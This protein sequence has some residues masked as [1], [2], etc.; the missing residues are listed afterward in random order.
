VSAQNA[1]IRSTANR[2][3]Q[4]EQ[5]F[6]HGR[7]IPGQ[8]S[9]AL[10]YRAHRQ[11]LELRALHAATPRSAAVSALPRVVPGTV[12]TPLGPAPLA[13]DA[14]GLGVQDYGPV[15]GRATAVAIDPADASGNTVY[16]GGA[17]G[18]VW[19][20]TNAGTISP[21]PSSVTWTALTD[22]Q[23]TLAVGAIAIQP[24]PANPDATRSVILVGTGET[25]NSSD[26]YYGLGILRSDNA[27]DTW[28]LIS[29]DSTGNRSFAGL[30]FSKIAFST[31][32]PSLVVAA[33]AGATQG[34]VEGLEDPVSANRGLYYSNDGGQS[35]N[36][37][38][39]KD[40]GLVIDP[41][42]ATSV[43]YNAVSGQ[44]FAAIQWHGIYSSSDGARWSRLNS[45]PDGLS[46]V[47]CPATPSTASCLLYRG[48]LAVVPGRNEMY[49]WFVDGNNLDRKIWQTKNGGVSWT[50][51]NDD[52][53][54]NCGDTLGCGTEQGIFNLELAAVPNGEVTDLYAGAVNL[55]K[56]RITTASPGCHGSGPDTFL[57]LTHAFGCPPSLG[58]IAHVHPNQ[59]ALSFLQIN[60]NHQVVMYF[61]NDG[62]IYRA[63]DG[64]TGLITGTCGG[65]NQFDSLNDNL[66]SITQLVSFSQHPTDPNTILA[67]AQDNG[68]PATSSSQGN[69]GW[70]NVN[71]GDGGYNEI[72]PGIPDQWFTSNTGVSIQRCAFG[73]NCRVQDFNIGPVVS[74]TTVGGDS[75]GRFT[76][77]ILDPQNSGAMLV[78][79]C[80][81]WRGATDGTGFSVLTD[82]F[83][84]GG[85][86]T[87]TGEEVN[88]VRAIVAGGPTDPSGFS[89]VMYAGTDGLGPLAPGGHIWVATNVS[90]GPAAWMDR[91]GG[92][93]PSGFPVSGIAIDKTDTTGRTAYVTVMGFH[94]PHVWKT[95]NAG[96]SWSDFTNNLPDAPANAV[97]VDGPARTVYAATDVGVFTS[98]TGNPSW[99]EVGPLP[100]PG[101]AAGFLPNVAVTALRMFNF[102]GTKKLRA[103]TYGRGLWEFT[104]AEGP[105]YQFTS[106]ANVLTTS[107][108]QSAA[109][110]VSL[111]AE[112]NF[113]SPVNLTCIPRSP[114][115]PAPPTCLIA[116]ATVTPTVSGAG[117]TVN[118]SGPVGDYRFSVHGIG[119]DVNRTTRDVA[120]TLHVVDF[121]LTGPAPVSLTTSQSG[122]SGTAAF[123][124]TATGAFNQAVDLSCSGLPVGAACSFQPSTSASP[125]SASPANVTLTISAGA[126][127]PVGTSQITL[128]G[129]VAGGP[130]R[131]QNLSLTVSPGSTGNPNF[132]IAVSNPSLTVNPNQTAV[133]NGTLTASGG[134]SSPVNLLCLGAVPLTCRFSLATLTPTPAGAA[135]TVTVGNDA[136]NH[137]NFT[138]DATGTDAAH[139]HRWT[140]VELIV[141]FDFAINNHSASQTVAAGQIATYNLDVV[142]LGNGGHFPGNVSLSCSGVGMPALST[143]TFTPSQVASGEGDTNVL[144][145]VVTTAASP[146]ANLSGSP[147]LLWHDFGLALTGLVLAWGGVT[148]SRG[149]RRKRKGGLGSSARCSDCW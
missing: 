74:N 89:N 61:A 62:G 83:E 104:L 43:V 27:G 96:I 51:L 16:V 7:A 60:S 24:Q 143:C 35:W 121:N 42:S 128:N 57:N 6:E 76:P 71:S 12:W 91:T 49:F 33:A 37:A 32:N 38:T 30:G 90:G 23:P 26:S 129:S 115:L 138:I 66:G 118:A 97:L 56:C 123:Q 29:H 11:K 139:L 112:N 5:W 92:T 148:Q 58:S 102:S 120:M 135:F 111:L 25:N 131:T 70:A 50:Q 21:N 52:N 47:S 84:T 15:A 34:V 119:T 93:N 99:I 44:F 36:Y 59:H 117:F 73:V 13:S 116:P 10:R 105:D 65:S 39:V 88:L 146:S 18:G 72:N 130:P 1:G 46:P 122:V 109:F 114:T 40:A 19:K 103:S 100:V 134:Y 82:N 77:F 94:V 63:L 31:V 48:E 106:P 144:V 17:Y 136:Q 78:G 86:E 87:C 127:T 145:K 68:S 14:S 142:P 54:T 107:A 125:I 141:G 137:F 64:Y 69:M 41:S 81:I 80:R 75:A 140:P 2:P 110:S 45:Q 126:N 28:T 133:F 3:R 9:A 98:S 113:N 53:I 8:A 132:A 67:G 147:H 79:T 20:S 95:F 124:V 85:S 55:F 149:R 22:D 108:G 101:S 4:R